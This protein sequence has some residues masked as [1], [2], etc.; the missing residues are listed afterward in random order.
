MPQVE[1]GVRSSSEALV[2]RD[3]LAVPWVVVKERALREREENR[4][5]SLTATL[6]RVLHKKKPYANL[7]AGAHRDSV[8]FEYGVVPATAEHELPDL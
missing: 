7:N 4:N 2:E 6:Q 5:T 8:A 1:L 3:E